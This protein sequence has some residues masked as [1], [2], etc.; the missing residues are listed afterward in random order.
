MYSKRKWIYKESG[1]VLEWAVPDEV[2]IAMLGKNV[3]SSRFQGKSSSLLLN[4][5][6]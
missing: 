5:L 3:R 1:N 6:G 4:N 2:A